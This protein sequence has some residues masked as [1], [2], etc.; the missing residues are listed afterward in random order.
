LGSF[1]FSDREERGDGEIRRYK[2]SLGG[3]W[4]W[5]SVTTSNDEGL[6]RSIGGNG[7]RIPRLRSEWQ[8]CYG[9]CLSSFFQRRPS[10]IA[11]FS[12]GLANGG[13]GRFAGAHETVSGTFVN[14]WL[15]LFCQRLSL[16][17]HL[18]IVAFTPLIVLAIKN[19]K[20]DTRCFSLCLQSRAPRRKM[21]KSPSILIFVRIH[22]RPSPAPAKSADATCAAELQELLHRNAP[23][24]SKQKL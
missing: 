1:V 7:N 9:S 4:Y 8:K 12:V 20:Q 3:N 5:F 2:L 23:D 15:V 11:R 21:N 22:E 16:T 19:R 13:I 18:W 17:L 14:H 6:R 10:F 24:S